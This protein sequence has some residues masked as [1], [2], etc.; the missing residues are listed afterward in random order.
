MLEDDSALR[1]KWLATHD[2][3]WKTVR[4]HRNAYFD[5]LHI[6]A[7]PSAERQAVAAGPAPS[8]PS[9]SLAD[10]V[11]ALLGEWLKRRDLVRGPNGLPLNDVPDWEHQAALWPGGVA[12]YTTI[13]GR[14]IYVAKHALPVW[15]RV[16]RGMDFAWQKHPFE[17]GMDE[18]KRVAGAPRPDRQEVISKGAPGLHRTREGPGVDYLL[19]FYLAQYLGVS[20]VQA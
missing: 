20:G 16:G 12:V 2:L 9:I 1:A 10:E 19:A 8:N 14:T 3:L 11:Q 17:V 18:K 13:E 4:H 7:Q 6:L 15:G 5:L